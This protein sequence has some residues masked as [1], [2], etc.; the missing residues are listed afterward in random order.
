MIDDSLPL[1]RGGHK[2]SQSTFGSLSALHGVSVNSAVAANRILLGLTTASN[3]RGGGVGHEDSQ[4]W[5]SSSGMQPG[6]D[7]HQC[8]FCPYSSYNKGDT[9]HHEKTHTKDQPFSC[10]LCPKAFT[11]KK[12]L[13]RHERAHTGEKP[14]QCRICQRVFAR[15]AHLSG[16]LKVHT[17]ERV[18]S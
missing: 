9:A 17:G 7:A 12:N 6:W 11:Q 8:R 3:G 14:F 2:S 13:Q 4:N 10:S 16:H 5:L 18:F 15:M 1:W